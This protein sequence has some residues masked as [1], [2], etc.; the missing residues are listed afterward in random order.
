[1]RRHRV[2]KLSN[3]IEFIA[4][5]VEQEVLLF[6]QFTLK[7]GRQSPY[8]FNLGNISTGQGLHRLGNRF[9][10]RIVELGLQINVLF[11]PAYKGIPIATATSIALAEQGRLVGFSYNRKEAK[12]HGEGG[13][14]AGSNLE[15]KKV[16]I[17]DDVVT[18]GATKVEAIELIREAGGLVS[19]VLVALDRMEFATQSDLS[20]VESLAQSTELPIY[21]VATLNDLIV[22]LK[23]NRF[24]LELRNVLEYAREY[25]PAIAV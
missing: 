5:M 3:A 11:G 20:A 23:R 1:M 13:V 17:V 4:E 18:D 24:Q 2:A 6:G 22:Y 7:S 16:L 19:G 10:N 8:F 21:S 12:Q 15:G 25:C 14:M 9:G